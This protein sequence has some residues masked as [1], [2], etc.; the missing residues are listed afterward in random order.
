MSSA[1]I[2]ILIVIGLLSYYGWRLGV[3]RAAFNFAGLTG[4]ALF[5]SLYLPELMPDTFGGSAGTA[6]T[7]AMVVI[8]ALVGKIIAGFAG[9]IVRPV[10]APIGP[11]RIMDKSAGLV[12]MFV[13]A[14]VI[15]YFAAAA[16]L[17][18][19]DMPYSESLNNSQ[20]LKTTNN[21]APDFIVEI[22]R[23]IAGELGQKLAPWLE[24]KSAV[25]KLR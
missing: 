8:G 3:V 2:A 11:L 10:V 9:R 22:A 6:T 21:L 1:D 19:P 7:I 18:V 14:V 24:L 17:T 5:A 13:S 23:N 15:T 20:L 16:L 25:S 4:G 12:L